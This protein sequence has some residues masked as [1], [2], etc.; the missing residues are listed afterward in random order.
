MH[1]KHCAVLIAFVSFFRCTL[2]TQPVQINSTSDA[3]RNIKPV[4]TINGKS[5]SKRGKELRSGF[6]TKTADAK[7]FVLKFSVL[8]TDF[9]FRWAFALVN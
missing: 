2:V 1:Y 7:P 3:R 6:F 8:T 9:P 4:G 5:A